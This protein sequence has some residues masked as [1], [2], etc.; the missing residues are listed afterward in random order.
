MNIEEVLNFIKRRFSKNCDWTN[1]NCYWFAAILCARFQELVIWYEPV[2]GHFYA[3]NKDGS[4]FFDWEGVHINIEYK[5]IK[6]KEIERTDPLWC[7][8]LIRDCIL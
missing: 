3:G 8:R 6:F 4:I 7:A 2:V 5:P 1:G